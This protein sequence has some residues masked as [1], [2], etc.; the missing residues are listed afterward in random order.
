MSRRLESE[1]PRSLTLSD[2]ADSDGGTP[3]RSLKGSPASRRSKSGSARRLLS[4]DIPS[5]FTNVG[6]RAFAH[7]SIT[8]IVI[9]ESVNVI[10]DYAFGWCESLTSITGLES[11]PIVAETAFEGC[12]SLDQPSREAVAAKGA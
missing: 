11:V 12:I 9:P 8:G 7:S 2:S 1:P 3:P 4:I 6:E 10:G 5:G